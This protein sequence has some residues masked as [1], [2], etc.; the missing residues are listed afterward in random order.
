MTTPLEKIAK[1]K[2]GNYQSSLKGEGGGPPISKRA[3]Y[4]QFFSFEG[5]PANVFYVLVAEK[6][7]FPSGW[8]GFR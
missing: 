1:E 7:T 2:T 8:V 3:I 6:C 4:F 5:F